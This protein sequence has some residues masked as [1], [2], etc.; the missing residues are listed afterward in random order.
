MIV[1]MITE[2]KQKK[3]T[4]KKAVGDIIP[5]LLATSMAVPGITRNCS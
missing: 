5:V 3:I 4:P 2:E 1:M